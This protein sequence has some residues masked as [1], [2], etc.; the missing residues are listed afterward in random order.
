MTDTLFDAITDG[1]RE[2][3]P[4][5]RRLPGGFEHT[6]AAWSADGPVAYVEADYLAAWGSSGPPWRHR[7]SEAW[8]G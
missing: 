5:F 8:A 6:L 4:G 2:R 1:R 7:H 3:A